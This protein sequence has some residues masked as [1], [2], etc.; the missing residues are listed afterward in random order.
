MLSPGLYRANHRIVVWK[1][2]GQDPVERAGSVE[3]QD[4]VVVTG[5]FIPSTNDWR[6]SVYVI[7]NRCCGWLMNP[8]PLDFVCI[9]KGMIRKGFGWM[10][11]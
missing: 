9:K 11:C 4:L 3:G 5:I 10:G 2:P 7:A 8:T 6:G 1:T